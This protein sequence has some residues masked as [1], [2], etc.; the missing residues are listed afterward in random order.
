MGQ[1]KNVL[2]LFS[3]VPEVGR[4]KTRLSTLK[5]GVFEPEQA[6]KLYRCMLLDVVQTCCAGL[7]YLENHPSEGVEDVYELVISTTPAANVPAMRE[8]M[9][10]A[11]PW[12]RPLT[13]A[14]DEGASFDEHYNDAFAQAF[15]GGA[16]AVFSMGCD[17]PA[18]T[19]YD[20][21]RGFTALHTL[22]ASPMGGIVVAPDQE[23]GVSAVGWTRTTSFDH[24]GVYYNRSGLTVLPAYIRKAQ[25]A[26]LPAL[27]LPP[28]PDVDTM[29]DLM[30][31]ITL[32]D[33]L[34]YTAG[35]DGDGAAPTH[36]RAW[37]EEMGMEEVLVPPN[38]L[39][40]PRDQIDR[41][42]S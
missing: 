13:V 19:S 2:L 42:A 31:N 28:I 36:T 17:M 41:P 23:M 40:D 20:I 32:V 11:G 24:S 18:L 37:L 6:C 35:F 33:A 12:P 39:F 38:D 29:A 26:G 27:Y 30:H 10:Q 5:D 34:C 9:E 22:D 1:R 16:D 21:V 4:V 8:L 14:C 7:S 25:E 15:A 3:K